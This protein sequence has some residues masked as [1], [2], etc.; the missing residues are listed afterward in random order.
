MKEIFECQVCQKRLSSAFALRRHQNVHAPKLEC[1][2]CHKG[3]KSVFRI[4]A[5]KRHLESCQ[6]LRRIKNLEEASKAS[7]E[8]E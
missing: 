4:D 8:K 6:E 3:I 5:M 7:K 1:P 2:Y